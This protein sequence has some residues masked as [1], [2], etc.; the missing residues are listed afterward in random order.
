MK[1][2]LMAG[3]LLLLLAGVASAQEP[4][5]NAGQ[6][7][8]APPSQEAPLAQDQRLALVKPI[9]LQVNQ[10]KITVLQKTSACISAAY[11]PAQLKQCREQ[12]RQGNEQI[13]QLLEMQR[14]QRERL[15]GPVGIVPPQQPMVGQGFNTQGGPMG[16]NGMPMRR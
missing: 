16:P 12:E 1:L 7:G 5:P 10:A 8:M 6:F 13:Y 3:T 15:G 4:F 9:L 2:N 11:T 14:E